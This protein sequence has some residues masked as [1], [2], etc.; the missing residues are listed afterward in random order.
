MDFSHWPSNPLG[1]LADCLKTA[2]RHEPVCLGSTCRICWRCISRVN[3]YCL[4]QRSIRF[5]ARVGG[6]N[7][8]RSCRPS[9]VVLQDA[10]TSLRESRARE[11]AKTLLHVYH[12]L[13]EAP[14]RFTVCQPTAVLLRPAIR[15]GKLQNIATAQRLFVQ[16]QS[17]FSIPRFRMCCLCRK[18]AIQNR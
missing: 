1:Y 2:C 13:L 12:L 10:L 16:S 15:D 14:S 11:T 17:R 5:Y 7:R 3:R 18:V 9:Q 4:S 8:R 6:S